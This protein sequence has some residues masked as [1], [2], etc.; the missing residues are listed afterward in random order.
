MT[1]AIAMV[2]VSPGMAPSTRPTATPPNRN[3]MLAGWSTSAKPLNS[4][5]KASMFLPP[6]A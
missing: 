6:F 2:A 3:R 1:K 4:M 5:D